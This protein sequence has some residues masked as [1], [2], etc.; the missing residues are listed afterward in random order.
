MNT[1]LFKNIFTVIIVLICCWAIGGCNSDT[2]DRDDELNV[3]YTFD[4]GTEG[5]VAGFADLPADADPASYELE[6]SHQQL[7]SGLTG[8]GFYIQGNNRSDDLFMFLKKRVDGLQANSMYR[9]NFSIDLATNVPEGLAGVGGAPGEDVHVKA[10][11]VA[12]EPLIVT[13]TQGWFRMNIDKGSQ[14]QGGADMIVI[15]NVAHPDLSQDS[16]DEYKIKSLNND[17]QVFTATTDNTGSLWCIVGTDSGFESV[18]ALYY[19]Q[20]AISFTK[21][22]G[23]GSAL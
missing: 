10:G 4:T 6:S 8:S 9:V 19:S 2:D 23:A 16:F 20:I 14:S 1:A 7:P 15:G 17:G 3:V 13:D 11:A 18:T 22:A 21:I 5:W 12:N